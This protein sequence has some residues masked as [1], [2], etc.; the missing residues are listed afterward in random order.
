MDENELPIG[1]DEAKVRRVLAHYEDQTEENALIED[2][3]VASP[4]KPQ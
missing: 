2:E 4:L 3:A 1:W